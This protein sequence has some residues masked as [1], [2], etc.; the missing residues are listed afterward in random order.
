MRWTCSSLSVSF[1][2][3]FFFFSSVHVYVQLLL[4]SEADS[5]DISKGLSIFSESSSSEPW[6]FQKGFQLL[7]SGAQTQC[8]T[9]GWRLKDFVMKL[10]SLWKL[11]C[12]ELFLSFSLSLFQNK[13]K[14]ISSV[15]HRTLMLPRIKFMVTF[16]NKQ[17]KNWPIYRAFCFTALFTKTFCS[18]VL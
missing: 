9:A 3:F 2:S 6:S 7:V 13:A 17:T 16:P 8:L 10:N 1:F 15:C 11:L 18:T 12:D 14:P 4:L 5:A